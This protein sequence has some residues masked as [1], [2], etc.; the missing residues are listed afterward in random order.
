MK[1]C[2][3]FLA[4][5]LVLLFLLVVPLSLFEFNLGHMVFNRPHVKTILIGAVTES[6]LIP[7]TLAW[8]SEEMSKEIEQ[9]PETSDD[10]TAIFVSLT[11]EDWQ[12]IVL[13]ITGDL[14]KVLASAP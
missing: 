5:M 1:G 11:Q 9:P 13:S 6:Q 10:L 8:F 2:A 12:T 14:A 4:L 7:A 3:R